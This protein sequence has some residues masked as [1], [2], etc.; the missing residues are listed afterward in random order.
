[1]E[2]D[3]ADRLIIDEER[4]LPI[5]ELVVFGGIIEDGKWIKI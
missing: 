5:W 3:E 2:I 1:V 4:D